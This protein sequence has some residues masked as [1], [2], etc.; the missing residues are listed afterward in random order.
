MVAF[1]G[2]TAPRLTWTIAAAGIRNQHF[3][4]IQMSVT[5]RFFV[6]R[7]LFPIHSQAEGERI[8]MRRGPLCIAHASLLPWCCC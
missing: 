4:A 3:S 7:L 8:H 5:Y 2:L 6:E 1:L